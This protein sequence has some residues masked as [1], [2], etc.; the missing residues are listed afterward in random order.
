M[1]YDPRRIVN[2]ILDLGIVDGKS[3]SPLK[4]QK[5]LYYGHGWFL[6]LADDP[7]ITEP[8]EAWP[9]GPVVPSIYQEFKGFG[10]EPITRKAQKLT[11]A[12]G[13]VVLDIPEIPIGEQHMVARDIL[14]RV[15][16][17]Y[18]EYTPVQLSNMTHGPD[19]PWAQVV[20]KYNGKPPSGVEIP[21][22][23]IKEYFVALAE[24][25]KAT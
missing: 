2:Y 12:D 11:L 18:K 14:R 13:K 19:T 25:N 7:L 23:L 17:Q 15:W 3:I 1:A 20:A 8:V 16:D 22:D 6:G 10:N 4:L 5:L 21:N 24:K 9:Y